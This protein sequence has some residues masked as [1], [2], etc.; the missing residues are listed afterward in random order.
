MPLAV[1]DGVVRA[2]GNK[3]GVVIALAATGAPGAH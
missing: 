1:G 2:F 3:R